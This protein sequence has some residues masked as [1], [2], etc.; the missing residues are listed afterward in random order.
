MTINAT[1]VTFGKT[2]NADLAA[3]NRTLTV[4]AGGI[5]SFNG[6][7]GNSQTLLSLATDGPGSTHINGGSVATSGNQTYGDPV[8]LDA[9]ANSTTLTG[10]DISFASTVR[11]ATD[12]EE[13]LTVTGSGNHDVQRRRGGQQP[14]AGQLDQ[15]RR[16][17]DGGQRRCGDHHGQTRPTRT[18]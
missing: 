5:T 4:N 8:L 1:T 13:S 6:A 10:V 14:A 15:Q 16:R 7:V 2:V 11:S 12:G 3:N 9:A 18:P 17:H